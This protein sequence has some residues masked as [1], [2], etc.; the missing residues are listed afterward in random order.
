MKEKLNAVKDLLRVYRSMF[1]LD[2]SSKY[3]ISLQAENKFK[4]K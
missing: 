3:G 2:N 4:Y 1:S